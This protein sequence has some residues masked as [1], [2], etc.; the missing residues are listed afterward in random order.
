MLQYF[1]YLVIDWVLLNLSNGKLIKFWFSKVL[2]WFTQDE[3]TVPKILTAVYV[4]EKAIAI[5]KGLTEQGVI[6][7]GRLAPLDEDMFIVG[8]MVYVFREDLEA[9][10]E[11]TNLRITPMMYQELYLNTSLGE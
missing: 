2:F 7:N 6:V 5:V 1:G 11:E 10:L 8:T 9:M 4:P 3:K